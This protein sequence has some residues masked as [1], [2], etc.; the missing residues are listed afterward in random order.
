MYSLDAC[1][2]CLLPATWIHE[3]GLKTLDVRMER[4]AKNAMAVAEYL[5]SHAVC[6]VQR[7]AVLLAAVEQQYVLTCFMVRTAC[8]MVRRLWTQ[9]TIQASPRTQTIPWQ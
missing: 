8:F 9:R 6:S 7:T 1:I 4:H 3:R 2:C 5:E